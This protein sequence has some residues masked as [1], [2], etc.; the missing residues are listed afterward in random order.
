MS[1]S[2]VQEISLN[3]DQVTGLESS[4]ITDNLIA[5]DLF[6]SIQEEYDFDDDFE[7]IVHEMIAKA[8]KTGDS[9]ALGLLF[10]YCE[11]LGEKIDVD[12]F[13][14]DRQGSTHL[15]IAA[16][17]GDITSMEILIEHGADINS[18]DSRGNTALSRALREGNRRVTSFLLD[19]EGVSFEE[20]NNLGIA[21]IHYA[22]FQGDL[23][24][25]KK[26]VALGAD[27]NLL[28]KSDYLSESDNWSSQDWDAWAEVGDPN[29]E[30]KE[31]YRY[32]ILSPL[33]VAHIAKHQELIDFLQEQGGAQNYGSSRMSPEKY[34]TMQG[35]RKGSRHSAIKAYV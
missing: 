8:I 14:N 29:G 28:T 3:Q 15:M 18:K 20:R 10:G 23:E 30:I 1:I 24:A 17:K 25:V 4:G 34:L 13:S 16:D 35:N 22:A 33:A 27:V 32:P 9:E 7:L 11:K 2:E 12:Y 19:Q 21:P 6:P 26:M 5:R 31:A